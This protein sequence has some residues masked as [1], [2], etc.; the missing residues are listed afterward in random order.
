MKKI[1]LAS[2]IAICGIPSSS[3]ACAN[4]APLTRA[5]VRQELVRL[6]EAGY[7]PNASPL[8]YPEE[9]QGAEARVAA[10][11]SAAYGSSPCSNSETGGRTI[12]R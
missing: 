7:R 11:N 12:S 6:E 1:I 3:F 9:I 4:D 8:H 5:Q 2:A 10:K